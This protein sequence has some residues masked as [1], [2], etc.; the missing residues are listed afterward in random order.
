MLLN[1]TT[2]EGDFL[3]VSFII[4]KSKKVNNYCNIEHFNI[5]MKKSCRNNK[6]LHKD[7]FTDNEKNFSVS[8]IEH[9]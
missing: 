5:I 7:K 9:Q 6:I 8:Y 4:S 2:W 3:V 1:Q